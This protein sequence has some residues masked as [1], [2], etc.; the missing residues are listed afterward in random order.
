MTWSV[1][2]PPSSASPA[3]H[4]CPSMAH[5]P[6]L[7][8]PAGGRPS[9]PYRPQ[10]PSPSIPQ[11]PPCIL[12]STPCLSTPSLSPVILILGGTSPS[13]IHRHPSPSISQVPPCL[14]KTTAG[15]STHPPPLT[16][17]RGSMSPPHCP[18]R[19]SSF[20][21]QVPPYLSK[22]TWPVHTP[23]ISSGSH[24][25]VVRDSPP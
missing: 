3:L 21:P 9:L 20:T 22:S 23:T 6:P 7:N 15:S 14:S 11:V 1:V 24:L 17:A 5:N 16:L 4:L 10:H 19:P 8:H 12:T 13:H 25:L 18:R 2:S